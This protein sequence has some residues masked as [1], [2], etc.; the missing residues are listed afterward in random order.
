MSI[1]IGSGL[2]NLNN[3]TTTRERL[4]LSTNVSTNS[5]LVQLR[6]GSVLTMS[7]NDYF[8]GQSNHSFMVASNTSAY[9][10]LSS[11]QNVLYNDTLVARGLTVNSNVNARS[12]LIVG[13]QLA[14]NSIQGSNLII[15]CN[16]TPVSSAPFV[17]ML[18]SNSQEAVGVLAN[19]T[20]R[21]AGPV[22]IG[23]QSP[24][25][26]LHVQGVILSSSN[27][28]GTNVIAQAIQ[29]DGTNQAIRF[30][31]DKLRLVAQTVEVAGN[32][33][34]EGELAFNQSLS[35]ES[36]IARG[37]VYGQFGHFS[38]ASVEESPLL[39][40][41]YDGPVGA[42]NVSSNWVADE[43]GEGYSNYT[44][45]VYNVIDVTFHPL[46]SN[47]STLSMDTY[48]R[49]GLGT[50]E[51]NAVLDIKYQPSLYETDYIFKA[52][53]ESNVT[54]VITKQ[55]CIG[56]GTCNVS[57]CLHIDPPMQSMS[58][59]MIG[60]YGCNMPFFAAYS[61]HQSVFHVDQRGGLTINKAEPWGTYLL[62]VEGGNSRLSSI[63]A[64]TIRGY[65]GSC[66]IDFQNTTLSNI[67]LLSTCN[68]YV[69][70]HQA[71]SISTNFFY[72]SNL[73][74]VGFRCFSW[75]NLFSISLSNFWL[76]GQGALMAESDS[77]LQQ[78]HVYDGKLKIVV[79]NTSNT[80]DIARAIY[81]R[82]ASNTSFR[83]HSTGGYPF[84]EL[85]KNDGQSI[86]TGQ[87]FL[88][89]ND[90]M[91]MRFAG[92][93]APRFR[94]LRANDNII[95]MHNGVTYF[96]NG[97]LGLNTGED[98]T[99]I[100]N[101]LDVKGTTRIR[102]NAGTTAFF[103]D[104]SA[105][106]GVGTSIS[107]YQ[108]HVNGDFFASAPSRFNSNLTVGERIG[109]GTTSINGS[110]MSVFSPNTFTG[111]TFSVHGRGSGNIASFS[112]QSSNV[113]VIQNNGFVGLGTTLPAFQLH[114]AGDLNFDG[115]LFEKGSRYISSQWTSLSN[116]DLF[117]TSNVGI[118]TTRPQSRLHVQGTSYTSGIASFGSNISSEGTVYAKGSFVSTSDKNLKT[119]LQPITNALDKV[120][121]MTGYTYD[122]TDTLKKE[123]G[124]VAQE[125]LDVLPQVVSKDD[126]D[127]YTIAYG[128]MAGL[129][130][131]AI[132]EL[133]K[134]VKDLKEELASLKSS[135]T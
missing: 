33:R 69:E 52:D 5:N 96:R 40:M 51:P 103:V 78:N 90:H 25:Q 31:S 133:Q 17:Q 50:R 28:V 44:S 57:H 124:L 64:E 38:N 129:F 11:N 107:T 12:N 86:I 95:Q 60:L 68:L 36:L 115:S 27:I 126:T 7:V 14:A 15:N 20:V 72:S 22:G 113:M 116:L 127:M 123:C 29:G 21:M 67:S 93:D 132:K 13:N 35:L 92:D 109:I 58:N 106:V 41:I 99:E 121:L 111:T 46:E 130:V 128:N 100:Q 10:S 105:R 97:S 82:G 19:G 110:Y 4:I 84:I 101:T 16:D 3:I 48:G 26:A 8:I 102:N 108:L 59:P 30:M 56:I 119:N 79:G 88:D 23:T 9:L 61:N 77:E 114:V 74:V 34:I 76:S 65:P 87:V 112:N 24:Q 62:D 39:D 83:V 32:L 73:S 117:F 125:V 98:F 53:G 43:F 71:H 81:A 42:C 131:Q 47:I 45:N 54:T 63:E 135:R 55:S 1:Q 104:E 134:E 6:G 49:V 120:S 94:I 91:S 18:Q 37:G 118:G 66:N 89:N 122:R 80:S 85:S 75:L 70:N 2:N